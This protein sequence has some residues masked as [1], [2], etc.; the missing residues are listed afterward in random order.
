LTRAGFLLGVLVVLGGGQLR[1][2]AAVADYL[3]KPIGSVRLVVEGRD[4]TEP[5]LL[6]LVST[7][8]GEPLSMVDVRETVAHLFSLRRFEGVSVDA[9]LENG[10][11]AL[12]A[13]ADAPG[14]PDPFRR[15]A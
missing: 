11:V 12:R 13:G 1:L 7:A 2:S 3:G 4:T 6:Q 15:S 10:R 9:A 5:L 8:T 14:R